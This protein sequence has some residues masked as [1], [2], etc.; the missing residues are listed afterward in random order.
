MWSIKVAIQLHWFPW[1]PYC[2]KWVYC[3]LCFVEFDSESPRSKFEQ[4]HGQTDGQNI[5]GDDYAASI[6]SLVPGVK[7]SRLWMVLNSTRCNRF[8]TAGCLRSDSGW[9]YQIRACAESIRSELVILECSFLIISVWRRKSKAVS[10]RYFITVKEE[11][12]VSEK[13]RTF[14]SN[15]FRMEFNFVLW[16]WP[17]KGKTRRGDRKACKPGGRKFGMEINFIHFQLYESYEIKF[18]TKI[19]SFTVRRNIWTS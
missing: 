16:N 1:S 4:E 5:A 15:S 3:R 7:N 10:F 11:I 2:E 13:F 8:T 14:P 12:F 9:I 18:P 17:K 6:T 19:S